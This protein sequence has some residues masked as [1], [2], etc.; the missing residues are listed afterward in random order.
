MIEIIGLVGVI[1]SGKTYQRD[2][3]VKQD[4]VALDFKDELIAMCEDLV[5]FGIRDNYDDFKKCI[6]GTTHGGWNRGLTPTQQQMHEYPHIMTGRIMLQRLGTEVMRKRDNDYWIKAWKNKAWKIIKEDNKNIVAAD[7]RF[8]NEMETIRSMAKVERI[9]TKIIFCDYKS[10]RYDATSTH[11][12]EAMA[13]R[14]L[15][16]GFK[17]G[18][19][20]LGG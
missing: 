9:K 17:D 10:D 18:Q 2:L 5:G 20:I 1:G 14:F 12:S 15:M 13:Q 11:P 19:E 3:L 16:D 7:V 4:F 8:D 6:I